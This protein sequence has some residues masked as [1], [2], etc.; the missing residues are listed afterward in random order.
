MSFR[1]RLALAGTDASVPVI[2]AGQYVLPCGAGAV[3]TAATGNGSLRLA[4]WRVERA[5]TIDRLAVEVTTAGEAGSVFRLGAYGDSSGYP[6]ALLV[7][8]GTVA[9]DT[10]GAKEVT[11]T[12]LVLTPGL[13]WIGGA[14]QVAATTPPTMRC[15]S[16]YSPAVPIRLGSSLPAT[17]GATQGYLQTGVSGAL[18]STFTATIAA[19]STM[20]RVLA[21]VA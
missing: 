16:N 1:R 20:P 9:G 5:I 21:R 12:A 3:A 6:G 8:G 11:I 14:A 2:P 4:P 17:T 18:P 15:L 13:Y 7:D 10:T 19:S